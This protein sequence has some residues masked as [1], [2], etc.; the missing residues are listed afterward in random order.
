MAHF[1]LTSL[2]CLRLRDRR[3]QGAQP[4]VNLLHRVGH[5]VEIAIEEVRVDVQRHRRRRVPQLPLD[6]LHAR[7]GRHQQPRG[8]VPQ[9]VHRHP[10]E[11]RISRHRPI[12]RPVEPR[13]GALELHRLAGHPF[14]HP[15]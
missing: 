15:R 2:R 9:P 7:A 3:T 4:V 10:R 14:P 11:V 6:D 1:W 12:A 5:R 13:P 8:D